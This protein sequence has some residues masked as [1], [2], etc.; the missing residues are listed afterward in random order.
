MGG[1]WEF[2]LT[3]HLR[4]GGLGTPPTLLPRRREGPS[5]CSSHPPPHSTEECLPIPHPRPQPRPPGRP[6]LTGCRLCG[7]I[8]LAAAA[9][10]FPGNSILRSIS[11]FNPAEK[12]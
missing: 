8:A 7:N 9:A 3:N 12:N 1:D 2:Q 11:N 10:L 6:R 4:R 5:E